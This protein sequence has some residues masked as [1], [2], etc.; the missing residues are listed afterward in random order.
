[1]LGNRCNRSKGNAEAGGGIVASLT[2]ASKA[3]E[4]DRVT[5]PG[6]VVEAIT[7]GDA[8]I[9]TSVVLA[10]PRMFGGAPLTSSAARAENTSPIG[11]VELRGKQACNCI[12]DGISEFTSGRCWAPSLSTT[13]RDTC[14]WRPTKP[15]CLKAADQLFH[16]MCPA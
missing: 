2:A 10:H 8:V 1:M 4:A 3:L 16:A 14:V 11:T 7:A 13:R 12:N 9:G 5:G 6:L 15:V